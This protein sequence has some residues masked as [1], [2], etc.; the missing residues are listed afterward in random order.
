ML[1][2]S[3]CMLISASPFILPP[4]V[5]PLVTIKFGFKIFESVSF[6][7]CLFVSFFIRIHF[8][9]MGILASFSAFEILPILQFQ[10]LMPLD[11]SSWG[12]SFFLRSRISYSSYPTLRFTDAGTDFPCQRL[13]WN[14]VGVGLGGVEPWGWHCRQERLY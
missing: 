7:E 6:C 10:P 2:S 4:G 14:R 12:W 8:L 13:C 5:S 3:A 9:F 1:Y 11:I